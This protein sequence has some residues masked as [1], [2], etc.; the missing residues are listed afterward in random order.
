MDEQTL[1]AHEKPH[2]G[3]AAYIKI[4]AT[5]FVLTALEVAAYSR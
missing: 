2:P 1:T 5:L 4:A 3:T